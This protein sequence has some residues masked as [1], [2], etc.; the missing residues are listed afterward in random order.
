M[1]GKGIVTDWKREILTWFEVTG[2]SP[3]QTGDC[4]F[5]P[6]YLKGKEGRGS[7]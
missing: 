4:V 1:K 5:N 7:S 6:N 3:E 2:K